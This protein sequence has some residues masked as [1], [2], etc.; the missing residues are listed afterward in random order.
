MDKHEVRSSRESVCAEGTQFKQNS[1]SA[2][3][4]DPQRDE[5]IQDM[6]RQRQEKPGNREHCGPEGKNVKRE[7]SHSEDSDDEDEAMTLTILDCE[8]Q[9]FGYSRCCIIYLLGLPEGLTV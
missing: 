5:E 1:V 2:A 8:A 9:Y 4:R 7:K 6:V 3:L